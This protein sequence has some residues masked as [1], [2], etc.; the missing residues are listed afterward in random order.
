MIKPPKGENVYS[1]CRG[2][3]APQAY[4]IL[5]RFAGVYHHFPKLDGKLHWFPLVEDQHTMAGEEKYAISVKMLT[6][7]QVTLVESQPKFLT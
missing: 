5:G 1:S 4:R 7:V 2:R 3:Y 6:T